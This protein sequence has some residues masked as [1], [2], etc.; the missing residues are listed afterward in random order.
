MHWKN[1]A[2][3]KY[4]IFL[5]QRSNFEFF[6]LAWYLGRGDLDFYLGKKTFVYTLLVG[7]TAMAFLVIAGTREKLGKRITKHAN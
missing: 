5:T 2:M 7:T 4:Q 3:T 6:F 1:F